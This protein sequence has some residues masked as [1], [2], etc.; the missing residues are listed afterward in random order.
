M[1]DGDDLGRTLPIALVAFDVADETADMVT[2]L[3]VLIVDG[4]GAQDPVEVRFPVSL[5]A[6]DGSAKGDDR[7]GT[8]GALAGPD[9]NPQAP[10]DTTALPGRPHPAFVR[11]IAA[12]YVAPLIEPAGCA[13][14]VGAGGAILG[15]VGG[16]C[17][18]A[19]AV[20]RVT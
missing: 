17:G 11:S 8:S 15:V 16:A 14:V 18:G 10:R 12:P 4:K 9:L 7:F 5:V 20:L 6:A 3:I 1:A 19:W 2:D 13:L